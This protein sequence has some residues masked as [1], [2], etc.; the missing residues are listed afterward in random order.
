MDEWTRA[1]IGVGAAIAMGSQEEKGKIADLVI[2]AM[3]RRKRRRR[4]T[5]EEEKGV[6]VAEE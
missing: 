3:R 2:N 4:G 1:E 5:G 6:R